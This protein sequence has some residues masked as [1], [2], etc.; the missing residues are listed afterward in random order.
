MV[1]TVDF[2]HRYFGHYEDIRWMEVLL[3]EDFEEGDM[4]Y[5]VTGDVLSVKT[6]S[7]RVATTGKILIYVRKT[8]SFKW[9]RGDRYLIFRPPEIIAGP[10]N[11]EEFDYRRFMYRKGITHRVFL[12]D[13]SEA[14]L[15]QRNLNSHPLEFLSDVRQNLI[16]RLNTLIDDE[17]AFAVSAALILGQKEYLTPRIRSA[18]S[19]SG[20]MHVLAVSGLHV[21]IIYL[22]LMSILGLL[23][24]SVAA[25]RLRLLIVVGFLWIYA[26]IT[27]LSPSVVR[28]ATM[29]TAVA[30]SQSISRKSSIYN[31]LAAAALI[32]LCINPGLYEEVGFQLSFAAV[33]AI[34]LLYPKIYG[35]WY[36]KYWIPDK[37]WALTAVSI[38]AQVGTFPLG[39]YYFNQFPNYF[40]LSNFIVIPAAHIVLVLGGIS[41]LTSDIAAIAALF[42]DLLNLVVSLLNTAVL[43][44]EQLPGAVS[45]GFIGLDELLLLYCMI[46][47]IIGFIYSPQIKTLLVLL[48]VVLILLAARTSLFLFRRQSK[49]ILV[50]N[51]SGSTAINF[52]DAQHNFLIADS[53]LIK[54]IDRQKF[55]LGGY[56]AKMGFEHAVLIALEDSTRF[57]EGPLIRENQWVSFY[58]KKILIENKTITSDSSI[59]QYA[60]WV[61]LTEKAKCFGEICAGLPIVLTPGYKYRDFCCE[62]TPAHVVDVRKSGSLLIDFE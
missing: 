50:T 11:P 43:H 14:R 59:L 22:I 46:A 5:K 32:M 17:E 44:I 20:A 56:W 54:D 8:E 9:S 34:V 1:S 55:H 4:S 3:T 60:D 57:E 62:S 19:G 21:G 25:V 31:T 48:S 23:G 24:K 2:S 39:L 10:Q 26:A 30:V 45:T 28:A 7:E 18:Y 33:L 42:G 49:N 35:L 6:P 61:V 13:P 12:R 40:L 38:A 58:R 15:V 51:I 16:N 27:G 29:F 41:L 36:V 52:T 47:L 53:A 37:L